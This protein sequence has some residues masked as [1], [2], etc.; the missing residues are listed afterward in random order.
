[1]K[2]IGNI[3]LTW[4]K[5]NGHRRFKIGVIRR[6]SSVGVRFNYIEEGVEKAQKEGFTV[7]TDFPELS[8][9]YNENVLEIFGQRLIKTDRSD[10]QRFLD[11]WA[12]DPLYKEEK[13]Y[14]LAHTQ[15]ILSTD[16]FEFL[17]D[18]H[19]TINLC[20]ITEISGLSK[21]ETP[22]GT[23]EV[24]EYL[25]WEYESSNPHDKEAIKIT[26]NG[27]T[28]G[29]VKQIHNRVFHKKNGNR[30]KI[31]VTHIDQNGHLNRVFIQISFR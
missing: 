18:F 1:M 29:Y 8:K 27:E 20:F 4:R 28:L 22:S 23:I 9:T 19:P 30:L 5:G 31:K 3:Y 16:N 2:S 10:I 14:M 25:N 15:G 26:K 21:Y 12:V 6:N 11:F 7:Y 24:G 17:A 13:Y